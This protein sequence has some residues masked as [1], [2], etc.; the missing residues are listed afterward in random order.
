MHKTQTAVTDT[1]VHAA[2]LDPPGGQRIRLFYAGDMDFARPQ[3]ASEAPQLDLVALNETAIRDARAKD[4]TP[5]V[6]A[7]FI[8]C[9]SPGLNA[10]RLLDE[11]RRAFPTLPIVVGVDPSREDAAREAVEMRADDY[12]VKSPRWL[13]RLP[14]RLGL[15]I[16]RQRRL[17]EAEGVK[18]QEQRLRWIIES[19][20]VCLTRLNRDGTVLAINSAGRALLGA[21]APPAVLR[22]SFLPFVEAS[23]HDAVREFLQ[24]VCGGSAVSIEFSTAD[25]E[26]GRIVEASG[27]PLPPLA[28]KAETALLVLRDVTTRR[29]LEQ[30]VETIV[31]AAG[32]PIV[33][34]LEARIAEVELVT[35]QLTDERDRL[36][37]AVADGNATVDALAR[38]LE[39]RG[40]ELNS[41]IAE[42][43]GLAR[44]VDATD[45]TIAT[46][47]ARI[48]EE[49][50]QL[51]RLSGERDRLAQSAQD[52]NALSSL[53]AERDEL[54]RRLEASDAVLKTLEAQLETERHALLRVTSE[55]DHLLTTIRDIQPAVAALKQELE[56]R[57]LETI[58]FAAERDALQQTLEDVRARHAGEL[59]AAV[60]ARILAETRLREAETHAGEKQVVQ[61]QYDD[62]A[63]EVREWKAQ[64]ARLEAEGHALETARAREAE[65]RSAQERAIAE[66]HVSQTA[67]L[68]QQRDTLEAQVQE[69]KAQCERV[70][71]ERNALET[72]RSRE[73]E[74][75]AA[76]ERAL[77]DKHEELQAALAARVITEARL[78]EAEAQAAEKLLLQQQHDAL[79]LQMRE[80]KAE[81]E[82]LD[83]ERTAAEASR[84]RE[85]HARAAHERAVQQKHEE[86]EA[87]LAARVVIE[88]RLREAEEQVDQKHALQQQYDQI[89]AQAREHDAARRHLEAERTV[90]QAS[91]ADLRA[92]AIVERDAYQ[93]L[94]L[95]LLDVDNARLEA[96][97][98]RDRLKSI[99]VDAF[100]KFNTLRSTAATAKETL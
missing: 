68:Q 75:R 6:E 38:R 33:S 85:A 18:A 28:D 55:R 67:A 15:V 73:A 3:F 62:L 35:R 63:A 4:S 41:V 26:S 17:S 74:A 100:D 40:L 77:Q 24:R 42:R 23:H 69:W 93:L 34:Q 44:R 50:I 13:A 30:H 78:R 86:L 39:E 16:R 88:A 2:H 43:D 99:L 46:L 1:S 19:A 37:L 57:R 31:P 95:Q 8:D 76:H 71:I 14:V 66:E 64:C 96:A 80:S 94:E 29:R 21:D 45:A 90:L 54:S 49:R 72:A 12:T 7:A 82:R 58:Q 20:P 52:G 65:A 97:T 36:A 87:A 25:S 70:E 48:T 92:A 27:I 47:Q 51:D 91:L 79:V 10:P 22:K 98:E 81:C 83:A 59:E 60:A 84:A 5:P 32:T 61:R 9:S 56:R 89:A 11:L 53:A